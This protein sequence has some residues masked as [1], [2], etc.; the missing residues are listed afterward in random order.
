MGQSL[1]PETGNWKGHYLDPTMVMLKARNSA[2]QMVNLKDHYSDPKKGDL[3]EQCLDP[4]K[5]T[6]TVQHLVAETG[7][8]KA[9]K[10]SDLHSGPQ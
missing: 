6:T 9:W 5:A 3:T 7:Y 10:K 2:M 8:Q 1:A 4:A